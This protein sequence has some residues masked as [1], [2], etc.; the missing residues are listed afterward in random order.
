MVLTMAP[1]QTHKDLDV[2]KL[3]MNL[4]AECYEA[5]S[6]FPWDEAFGM[7]AQ[8]RRASVSIAA[9]IAEGFGREST[10]AFIQFLRVAQGSQKE[11]ETHLLLAERVKLLGSETAT[12][13]LKDV[14][15]IGQMLNKLIRSLQAREP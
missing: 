7:T 5:T 14:E 10:P 13:L 1:I 6:S 8:I 11:L 9:N 4:A 3:A 2:W 15:R 12:L